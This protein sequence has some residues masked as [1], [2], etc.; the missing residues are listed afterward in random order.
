[1]SAIVDRVRK[2]IALAG[3]PNEHE[4]RS[5]AAMACRLMREHGLLV[6]DPAGHARPAER[7]PPRRRTRGPY[8][9]ARAARGGA[10]CRE[11]D[12]PIEDGEVFVDSDAAPV[13]G[14][15]IPRGERP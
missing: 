11:C 9:R 14:D 13:H 5:A 1:M 4:A 10:R 2:L 8:A 7:D 3:S 12:E 6:H 15:C